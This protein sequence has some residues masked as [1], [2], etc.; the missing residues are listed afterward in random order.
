MLASMIVRRRNS[1]SDHKSITTTFDEKGLDVLVQTET[2]LKLLVGFN[3][4]LVSGRTCA[5]KCGR[6]TIEV[7]ILVSEKWRTSLKE[8]WENIEGSF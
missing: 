3:F 8:E 2:E 4:A 6:A 1:S 5:V 7:V